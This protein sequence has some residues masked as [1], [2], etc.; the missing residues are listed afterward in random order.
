[1]DLAMKKGENPHTC[2][3]I[4]KICPLGLQG[5]GIIHCLLSCVHFFSKKRR[6]RSIVIKSKVEEKPSQSRWSSSSS[7]S[8][9]STEACELY[10]IAYYLRRHCTRRAQI[11]NNK[12]T[13]YYYYYDHDH[14]S[15]RRST[16]APNTTNKWGELTLFSFLMLL[17]LPLPCAHI[18]SQLNSL[19][20]LFSQCSTP[21]KKSTCSNL[22]FRLEIF[23]KDRVEWYTFVRQR[24]ECMCLRKKSKYGRTRWDHHHPPSWYYYLYLALKLLDFFPGYL[25][26]CCACEQRFQLVELNKKGIDVFRVST[27]CILVLRLKENRRVVRPSAWSRSIIIMWNAVVVRVACEVLKFTYFSGL[28]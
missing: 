8:S 21:S 19:R 9:P 12:Y 13:D 25:F 2:L 4:Q 26:P 15:S 10:C 5:K 16:C 24:K 7:S 20:A 6:R 3:F 11:R 1:M 23:K 17:L 18:L 22:L 14:F 27:F 28:Q